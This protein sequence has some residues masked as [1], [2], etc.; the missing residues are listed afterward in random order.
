[1]LTN[2]LGYDKGKYHIVVTIKRNKFTGMSYYN[3]EHSW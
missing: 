2:T 3:V 1:M